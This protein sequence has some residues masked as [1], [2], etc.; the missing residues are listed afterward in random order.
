MN[1]S[2]YIPLII[3]KKNFENRIQVLKNQEITVYHT[4]AS[5]DDLIVN[6]RVS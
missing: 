3:P 1:P 6:D 5:M 4:M 2:W